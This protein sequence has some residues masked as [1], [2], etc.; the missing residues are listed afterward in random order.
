MHRIRWELNDTMKHGARYGH[1]L[2]WLPDYSKH[3]G[4]QQL[5]AF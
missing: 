4:S 3:A 2:W 5:F 1:Y